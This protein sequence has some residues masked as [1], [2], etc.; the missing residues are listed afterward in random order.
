[1]QQAGD[2][3]VDRGRQFFVGNLRQHGMVAA[4]GK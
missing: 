2:Q 3:L 1:M 4:S